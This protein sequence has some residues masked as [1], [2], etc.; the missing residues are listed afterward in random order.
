MFDLP[1]LLE[2]RLAGALSLAEL[3]DLIPSEE[4]E[5]TVED[6]EEGRLKVGAWVGPGGS[7]SG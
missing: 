4:E 1:W 7:T 2:V 3:G 6:T 5:D